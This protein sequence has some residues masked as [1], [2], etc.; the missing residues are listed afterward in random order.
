MMRTLRIIADISI[1][2]YCIEPED[3]L[4]F[5]KKY[6]PMPE[7]SIRS[8][9]YR[10]VSLPGQAL[11]YKIGDEILKRLFVK[12]FG[13]TNNLIEDENIKFYDELIRGGTIPLELLC[14]KYGVDYNF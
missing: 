4:Q 11:C 5:F 9:I 3:I 13:R 2:Y 1:H 12:K 7:E 8:E 10:Y 6:L 14:K